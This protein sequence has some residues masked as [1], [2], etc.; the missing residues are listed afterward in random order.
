MK[1]VVQR[2]SSAK[3]KVNGGIVS[4]IK[5]GLLVLLAVEK[6]DDEQDINWMAKKLSNL[7]VFEDEQGKMNLSLADVGAE[8]MVISNFTVAGDASKGNRPGFDNAAEFEKGKALFNKVLFS[9]SQLGIE[10]KTGEFGS[11]MQ[12]ELV[13]AGPVTI[14]LDS[15]SKTT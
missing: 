12:I 4:S 1:A 2:V 13:N 15:P 7:R 5:S 9:L 10:P 8:M 6:R 3:V 14:I 11:E